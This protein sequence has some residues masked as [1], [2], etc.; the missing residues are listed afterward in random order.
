[1]SIAVG[2]GLSDYPFSS[3]DLFWKWVGLCEGGG[4][5]SLW[6]TDRIV[7]RKPI[8]ESLT[9][10]AAI[11]GAT[12]RI[13]FGMNV[14][15]LGLRDPLLLAKQCATIDVLSQGRLLPAFGVGN[16]RAPEWDATSLPTKG[17]GQ[18]TNEGL[19]L[20]TKLWT[21]DNVT[22]K[23]QFYD[24]KS[25]SISPKP[26]QKRLPMWIGGSSSAAIRRTAK[27][28][29]GW[30]SGFETP[31]EVES[32]ILAIKKAL[33]CE[34]RHIEGDHYGASFGYRF[35]AW[36]DSSVEK[37]VRTI[38]KRLGRDPSQVFAVGDCNDIMKRIHQ[39][40]EAGASKFILRPIADDDANVLT[41]S[42]MLINE[43]LPEI[44]KLNRLG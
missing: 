33:I 27:Y 20:I 35:G 15:S 5:D 29:T 36:T 43:I 12:K 34:G 16:I 37:S 8:L 14:V 24:Y 22:L 32:T 6:Q 38:E 4:V 44:K 31:G 19:H 13:K 25:A 3:S 7:S 41:Q 30:Q 23:G 2:L 17:R 21:E 28:G 11:A 26:L 1:M 10:M 42:E 40:M 18:R 9:T 39:Y